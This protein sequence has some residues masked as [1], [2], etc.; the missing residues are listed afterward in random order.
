MAL[1]YIFPGQGS[2]YPGMGKDLA[3]NFGAARMVFEEVDDA[4]GFKI[5][6]LCFEGPAE[7]L[8]LTENTQPAILSVSVWKL[9]DFPGPNMS[10][11]TVLVSTRH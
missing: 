5:S 2:Q 7:T 9:K 8:Q 11:A 6:E 3:E 1:A 4:L 10:P